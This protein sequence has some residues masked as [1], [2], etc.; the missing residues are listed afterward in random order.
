MGNIAHPDCNL[1]YSSRVAVSTGGNTPQPFGLYI[2]AG[3][4]RR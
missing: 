3:M 4:K 2:R 1:S